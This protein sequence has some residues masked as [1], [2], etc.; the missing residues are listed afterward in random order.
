MSVRIVF[1]QEVGPTPGVKTISEGHSW[2]WENNILRIFSLSGREIASYPN[3]GTIESVTIVEDD[4]GLGP[5][6][7]MFINFILDETGSMW[8]VRDATIDSFNE[9]IQSLKL[10]PANEANKIRFTLTQFNSSKTQ[11]VCNAVPL[12]E[13]R[14]LTRDTYNPDFVTPLYDAIGSTITSMEHEAKGANVLCVIQ[15]DGFENASKE[16]DRQ[17]IFNLITQ[18]QREGWTFVFLGADQDAWAAGG[19]I[20]IPQLNT[21]SYSHTPRG[22]SLVMYNLVHATAAYTA[23]GGVATAKMFEDNIDIREDEGPQKPNRKK[24]KM[25]K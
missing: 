4:R 15:T 24:A 21:L 3:D 12:M 1:K 25:K 14:K 17:K 11:V 10:R 16:W 7:K 19:Q 8:S 23:S 22:T 20:G 6:M 13:V 2:V 5:D 18:K 9:Y